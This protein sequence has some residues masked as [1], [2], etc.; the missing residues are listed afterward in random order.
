[1]SE[2]YEM[3]YMHMIQN[4]AWENDL[5]VEIGKDGVWLNKDNERIKLNDDFRPH[6]PMW[7]G[8]VGLKKY[9]DVLGGS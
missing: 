4:L 5:L 9:V 7:R 2:M 3:D 1:M 6:R 8:Y